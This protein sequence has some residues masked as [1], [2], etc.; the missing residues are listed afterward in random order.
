MSYRSLKRVLGETSLE[1]K[2]RLLFGACLLLLIT[3]SFWWYGSRTENIVYRQNSERG[4]LLVLRL[5]ARLG[6]S[7]CGATFTAYQ[8]AWVW[9]V[10]KPIRS[11]GV[12]YFC[13]LGASQ[14]RE[15][16]PAAATTKN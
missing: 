1:R 13:F 6:H 9:N 8:M 12:S 11:C 4:R 5:T 10:T 2:C 16:L 7:L 14:K 15:A 3:A